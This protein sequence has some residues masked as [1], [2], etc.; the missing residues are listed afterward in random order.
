MKVERMN[1]KACCGSVSTAFKIDVPLSKDILPLLIGK[2]F[3]EAKHF[4][5]AGMLYVENDV[6]IIT[7][8][9]GSNII[10]IKCKINECANSLNSFEELL[11]NM[12]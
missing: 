1:I 7:G 4:T 12:E 5:K 10:H 9:F 8:P 11:T 6:V 2:G 3:T